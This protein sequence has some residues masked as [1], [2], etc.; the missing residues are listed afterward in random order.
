MYISPAFHWPFQCDLDQWSVLSLSSGPFFK[1]V[2]YSQDTYWKNTCMNLKSQTRVPSSR[3][4]TILSH[5]I[6]DAYQSQFRSALIFKAEE[7]S[8]LTCQ[9]T[10]RTNPVKPWKTSI[11]E[12]CRTCAL[13][14]PFNP[15]NGYFQT[16]WDY[17]HASGPAFHLF[18]HSIQF[19]PRCF[20]KNALGGIPQ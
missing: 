6:G 13:T 14:L 5:T 10:P 15:S 8:A 1:K 2:N 3:L 11:S 18:I 7:S 4:Q 20:I 9:L 19:L 12:T 17:G 16:A